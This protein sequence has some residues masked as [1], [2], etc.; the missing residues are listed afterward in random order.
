M[1]LDKRLAKGKELPDRWREKLGE[2]SLPRPEGP[3]VWL[4]AVGLG[5]ILALRGLIGAMAARAPG[6]EFLVT[7]TTRGSAEVFGANLPPRT[8]HQFLPLDAPGYLGRFLDHWRPALSVWAEQD[9]W[10]GAV[11]ATA[12]RGIP[13][14]LV[15]ARMNAD[16][17]ARRRRWRGLYADLFARFRVIT[18]QDAATGRHL[19]EL[20]AQGVR[21]TGSL[22]AAAPAL[23]ADPA[24]LAQAR[25]ALV[26][27]NPV[28]LASSHAEDE[29]V[30]L[31]A[32]PTIQHRPL[33]LIAPRDPARGERIAAHVGEFGLTATRRS[34]GEGPT[35]DVWIVDTLG[36]M[37]LWYRLCPVTV[38]GGTF[39][40]T[41]GH[42]PW[43]PAASGSAILHGPRTANFA[44]DFAA[45]HE[46]GAALQ[47]GAESLGAALTADHSAM[48]A[49]AKMLSDAAQGGVDGLAAELLELGGMA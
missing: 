33:L 22:K 44:A 29:A 45:L 30:V 28:L 39:G 32:L 41:E 7:S 37:G 16:A 15:N 38:I 31:A 21:V 8:R 11:V 49:R 40:M 34:T 43:E 6:V 27:R 23:A 42:N 47:A 24:A 13:L 1:L 3:V 25:A 10:P 26:G 20:G 46:H 19:A 4:H 14:A 9:L 36:E 18:A 5:E 48:A 35:A 2:P 12:R 17:H